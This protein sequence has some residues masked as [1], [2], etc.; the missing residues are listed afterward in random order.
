MWRVGSSKEINLWIDSC[1]SVNEV[2][3][4]QLNLLEPVHG[5]YKVRDALNSQGKGSLTR[6]SVLV[7]KPGPF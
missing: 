7:I 6:L 1:L 5:L 2:P 4:P 3:T